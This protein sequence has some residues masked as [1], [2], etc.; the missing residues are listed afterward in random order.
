MLLDKF[1]TMAHGSGGLASN[2]L[3]HDVFIPAFGNQYLDSLHDGAKLDMPRT[4]I[5]FST[6]SYVVR[7]HFFAGGDIGKLAICGTVNDLA[8]TGARPLYISVGMILE[9][10]FPITDLRT[11]CDSMA[12]A[13]QEAD[14]F[15]VTGDT[16]VV[17]KGLCDGIYINTAGIGELIV[18]VNIDPTTA[19]PGQNIILSGYIG[20]HA[21][22][23]LALRHNLE[24]P[25][26]L[27]SD[28][29]PLNSL[30]ENLLHQLPTNITVLRDPTRGGVAAVLNEIAKQS[31]VGILIEENSLPIRKEV[32]GF[33]DILGFDPLYLANEGKLVMFV[34]EDATEEAL[35]ILHQNPYGQAAC[36]IGK[37]VA[38]PQGQVGLKTTVGG[39][40]IVDMPQGELIPRIC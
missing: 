33:C 11:I 15:I 4:K 5:A 34:D 23:I 14:V 31:N 37:V 38:K 20:D 10:G 6:D 8:M 19:Y 9:E 3:V 35:N 32:Q 25:A 2:Q 21:A 24:L 13:A 1:I 22:T 26:Q 18:D 27:H 30:V 28:C 40:R 16:K 12:R 36:V 29:A 7:P 17:N 39:I